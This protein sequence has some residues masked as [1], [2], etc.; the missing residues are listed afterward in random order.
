MVQQLDLLESQPFR[1]VQEG[2]RAE[3]R[4]WLRRLVLW[5]NPDEII[6]E[7]ALR[8][9]LNIIWS[10]DPADHPPDSSTEQEATLGHGAG[11]TLLCRLIR[12]VLGEDRF[13]DEA[14]RHRIAHAFED[15]LVGA[16]VIIDGTSWSVVRP[17]GRGRRHLA[18]PN[19]PLE[20]VV[21]SDRS[22]T[23]IQPLLEA[24]DGII[25]T[26]A[27]VG[28]I[29]RNGEPAW[30]IALA[31]LTRDQ[32]CRFDDVLDW[33][34]T[35]S[36]SDSPALT[37]DRLAAV[38]AL[39]GA[40][41]GE[42]LALQATVRDLR[43][44][45]DAAKRNA[46]DR[47]RE[48]ARL[49]RRVLAE[50]GLDDDTVPPGQVGIETLRKT[51]TRKLAVIASVE[52]ETDISN[53]PV[54]RDRYD[55]ATKRVSDL[56][57]ELREVI[58][59]ANNSTRMIER[60]R[61]AL[62]GLDVGVQMVETPVCPVCR[63]P[64]DEALA[65]GCKISLN[66][67][68]LHVARQ[69]YEQGRREL[70]EE[71]RRLNEYRRDELRVRD[72]LQ[73][74][75]ADAASIRSML[76]GAETAQTTHESAWLEARAVI[77]Q[78][79]RLGELIAECDQQN[80]SIEPI[81]RRIA[82][83]T[84]RLSA[85]RDQQATV[86]QRLSVF[87]DGIIAKLVPGARGRIFL[88]GNGIHPSVELG[89]DRSTVAMTSIKVLAFDLAVM[90][91]SIEGS[92]RLPAFLIHDSPREADMGLGVYRSLFTLVHQLESHD[93]NALFQYILTTTTSP[94]SEFAIKPWLAETLLGTPANARLLKCDL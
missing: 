55:A 44:S 7:I 38:R 49:R 39:I 10:P 19:V 13:A 63:V 74:A 2:G 59:N 5:R 54:I 12:Y 46:G 78:V 3:P 70:E 24:I 11:K 82:E 62:P 35:E 53:L 9:G 42:E 1:V 76:K 33:R 83:E 18:I 45:R 92:I 28:L 36:D 27:V 43:R 17:I 91:M 29:T 48:I 77:D 41:V 15:G 32:E 23:G 22:A 47:D 16:E 94:P 6:R 58:A 90:C 85:F 89:G 8:P 66:R 26:N 88:D 93:G 72:E 67:Q 60:I 21:R 68:N 73:K 31:W 79:K 37:A 14:Q 25:L 80:V 81:E 52:P 30:P 87:F 71:T 51:A 57:G 40:V 20:D 69:R 64:I 61:A 75:E 65:E 50:L 34:A 4:L 56:S 86:F 84:E